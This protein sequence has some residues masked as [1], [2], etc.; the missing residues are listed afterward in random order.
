M[1]SWFFQK[2]RKCVIK[3]TVEEK[4]SRF[5]N[6]CNLKC[7][8]YENNHACLLDMSVRGKDLWRGEKIF[9]HKN[10]GTTI[11][12]N[13]TVFAHQTTTSHGWKFASASI[14]ITESFCP[15]CQHLWRKTIYILKVHQTHNN[16]KH[17]EHMYDRCCDRRP[18]IRYLLT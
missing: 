1:N 4:V 6:F 18:R 11:F 2:I 14:C 10:C 15:A 12:M 7:L 17:K 8:F 5:F 3:K 13:T 16:S 9:K